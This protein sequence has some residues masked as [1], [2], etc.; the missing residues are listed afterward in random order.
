MDE[1]LRERIGKIVGPH[2]AEMDRYDDPDA[3]MNER[4]DAILAEIQAAGYAVVPMAK[5]LDEARA[6]LKDAGWVIVSGEVLGRVGLALWSCMEE[7]GL[8]DDL[9][10]LEPGDRATIPGAL[11]GD[12]EPTPE[13]DC[14]KEYR[15]DCARCN[16]VSPE[17]AGC[18]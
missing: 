10:G 9:L 5:Y 12:L 8:T 13:H 3:V 2:K 16:G 14:D 7:Y 17:A 11:T 15:A 1:E 4:V 18:W 6:A